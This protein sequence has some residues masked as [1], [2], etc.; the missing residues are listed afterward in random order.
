MDSKELNSAIGKA[1]PKYKE[2]TE[3]YNSINESF[4]EL[5]KKELLATKEKVAVLEAEN[6]R[7]IEQGEALARAVMDDQMG[8]A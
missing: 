4:I 3:Q 2:L 7:L 6:R 1:W 8:N 5:L